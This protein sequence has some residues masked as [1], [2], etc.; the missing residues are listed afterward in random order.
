VVGGYKIMGS[1]L[2]LSK[3]L[4]AKE[5]EPIEHGS[6]SRNDLDRIQM[7]CPGPASQSESQ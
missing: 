1:I 6:G 5:S 4:M 2:N 7:S 3:E